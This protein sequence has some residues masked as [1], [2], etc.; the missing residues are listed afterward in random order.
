MQFILPEG[1]QTPKGY[2]QGVTT[3]GRQIFVAGYI[4]WGETSTFHI[5]DFIW[6]AG[7]TLKNIISILRAA[8]T[9]EEH[10]TG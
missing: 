8:N 5:D 3:S 1:S 4:G 10:I 2:S 7:Q 9:V 6:E